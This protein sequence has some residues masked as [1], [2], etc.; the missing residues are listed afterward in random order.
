MRPG[1]KLAVLADIHANVEALEAVLIAAEKAGV[2]RLFALGDVVGYG[3]DPVACIYRLREARAV[4]VLGNHDQA[5]VE[6]RGVRG[7][8]RLA[9]DSIL[10]AR[11][12]L[13]AAELEYLRSFAFR[14][15]QFGAVFAHANPIR[16]EEWQHLYLYDHLLWCMQRTDWQVN[17]VGHTHHPGIFCFQGDQVVALTSGELAIGPHCYLINPGS[18]GQPRDGDWRASFAL[19]DLDRNYLELRR[20]EYP[21]RRTQEK[22]CQRDWPPY[23][24]QR[25]ARGE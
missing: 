21:V 17:F 10:C 8:N 11:P 6:L 1:V 5:M 3:P 9:R 15:V 13:A 18:V 24:A 14:H 22:I 20:V 7:L 2:E 4:C 23:L 12:L 25:L 16:P 19:W